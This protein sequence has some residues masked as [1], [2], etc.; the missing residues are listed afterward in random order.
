MRA[1]VR[2]SREAMGPFGPFLLSGLAKSRLNISRF[3]I[4]NAAGFVQLEGQATLPFYSSC[5]CAGIRAIF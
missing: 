4:V 1:V 3:A 2:A 5:R